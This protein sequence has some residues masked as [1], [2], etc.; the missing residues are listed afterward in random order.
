VGVR[1]DHQGRSLARLLDVMRLP[2]ARKA[3]EKLRATRKKWSESRKYA[4]QLS[5]G[6]SSGSELLVGHF[7]TW[8][9]VD[10]VN[11][12][13][14]EVV[15]D[16]MGDRPQVIV[17]TGT[18]AWGTDSTRLWDAYVSRF[19]GEFWS[20]D[21]SPAPSKRLADQ[22]GAN[23]H[24]VVCDSVTF[25][26]KLSRDIGPN[27]VNMCYLDSWDLDW[28]DP[29][30]AALHGLA[31][32]HAVR[33]MMESQSVLMIDDSPLGLEWV[34]EHARDSAKEFYAEYGYWP[35]KGALVHQELCKD[36]RVSV[37]WHGYNSVYAFN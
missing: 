27:K 1:S 14:F 32:W 9:E 28:A 20:V 11:R 33:P 7:E 24:L 21:I 4:E 29:M 17:E 25:L 12:P 2:G 22:V 18:S 35:G 8:S 13:G 6:F 37:V 26:E 3:R 34:P 5:R 23:T 31:E 10:H 30:P 16:L 19:G 36:P 15:I